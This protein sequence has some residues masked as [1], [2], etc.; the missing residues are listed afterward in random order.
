VR[1]RYFIDPATSLPHIYEH[2]ISESEV[3][4]I[5]MIQRKTCTVRMIRGLQ[6]ARPRL[7]A[8]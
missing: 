2:G 5:L 4:E 7:D 6:L 3:E 1:I 8:M